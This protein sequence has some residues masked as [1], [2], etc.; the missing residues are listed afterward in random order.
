M[1]KQKVLGLFIVAFVL[2]NHSEAQD[3]IG[4][5]V[6]LKECV[7]I[8]IKNNLQVQQNQ[9]QMETSRVNWKQAKDYLLPTLNGQGSYGINFGRSLNPYT[10]QYID[11]QINVGNYGLSTNLLLFSGLQTQNSIKQYSYAYDASK[12]DLQQQKDNITLGVLLAYL[13]VLSNQDLLEISRAQ[14]NVD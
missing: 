1:Q 6:N 14:A 2:F 5:M 12:M 13:Q 10:N 9:T 7:D 4:K 8:A 3:T 11:Q